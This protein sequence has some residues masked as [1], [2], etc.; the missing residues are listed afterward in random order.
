MTRTKCFDR[1]AK[2]STAWPFRR[3]AAFSSPTPADDIV[4]L[5][6]QQ[7]ADLLVIDAGPSP[8]DEVARS[9]LERAP[10]DIALLVEGDAPGVGPV[11]VPFGAAERDWTA[12]ELGAWVARA[13]ESPLRLIGAASDSGD[14]GRNASRLLADASLIVQRTAGVF[15][16]PLLAS[17]GREGIM[18]LAKGAG[19]L[20]VGLSDRWPQE[21]FGPYPLGDRCITAGTHRVRATRA[22]SRRPGPGREPD[23]IH[24]VHDLGGEMTTMQLAPGSTFAGYRIEAEIGRGGMGVVYRATDL[25]LER[26]VALKLIAPELAA[27]DGFRRRFLQE[28]K[29]TASLGPP[30]RPSRPRCR[31]GGRASSTSPCATW[32]ART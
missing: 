15:A 5:A 2:T 20:V 4:R 19:L 21:G 6:S 28:S 11:I 14:D 23:K 12:L 26:P 22:A 8:L 16:E 1:H 3:V 13:T 9:V 32:R 7:D 24:M 27:D 18:A 10:C 31:R 30:A 25:A 29:L 17:P